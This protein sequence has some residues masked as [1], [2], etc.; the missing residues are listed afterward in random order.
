M[1][2]TIWKTQAISTRLQALISGF[3]ANARGNVAVITALSALPIIS[4]IGCVVDYSMATTIKT[5][6]QAAADAATL[7]AVSANSPLTATAKAMTGNGAV[8][9]GATYTQNFFDANLSSSPANT[10]YNSSTR[11]ATVTK[12][13][14]TVTATLSFTAAVPTFFLGILGHPTI[15][16]T[17]QSTSSYTLPSYIDFYLMLDVSGSMGMPS[18]TA[19]MTRLQSVNPD[20]FGQYPSGCTF[21]CH[22]TAQGA[23]G[24]S[25][26]GPTPAVGKP[27]SP[28]PG[29]YCQ[30]FIISRLGTTPAAIT[31][32]TN[33]T[34]GSKVNWTNPQVSSCA[35]PGTTSCIQ[36]R[37]DAVGY[38][39]NALLTKAN[40][41][42]GQ[43]GISN[44]F[45][46]GLYPFIQ[47]LC[48]SNVNSSS[49]CS[50]GL[51]AN[52]TGSTINNFATQLAT[53]GHGPEL[54][55]WVRRHAF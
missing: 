10:G 55:P 43:D 6:L 30:G 26:Q 28:S 1:L 39:A 42:E 13:G 36:L 4:A 35:S 8:A 32:G 3:L 38:A 7:A 21:A 27:T 15:S 49:S 52:L 31:S 51:T 53:A 40:A 25:N 48:Y 17:G 19:E 14:T 9:N 24:Q 47:N 20:N 2:T 29:G 23:C 5:R 46:V 44:Q 41:T 54:H 16:L 33:S 11:T 18:T 12:S 22:F 34:N 37:L 45:R 50:V